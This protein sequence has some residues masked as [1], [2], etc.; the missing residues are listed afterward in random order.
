MSSKPRALLST[1]D[2][3]DSVDDNAAAAQ[4]T[5]EVMTSDVT[6]LEEF[7]A[8]SLL[9]QM[10]LMDARARALTDLVDLVQ[11]FHSQKKRT[12]S[13]VHSA[14][15]S[16]PIIN[17]DEVLGAAHEHRNLQFDTPINFKATSIK[18]HSAQQQVL[19]SRQYLFPG[20]AGRV[21]PV[22][23]VAHQIRV[24]LRPFSTATIVAAQA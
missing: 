6:S 15:T 17:N 2:R 23:Q 13:Q 16:L 10:I 3:I 24:T 8:E 20:A 22:P 19:L 4:H 11:S 7:K 1:A 9:H 21:T 5:G 14:C 12:H 18:R